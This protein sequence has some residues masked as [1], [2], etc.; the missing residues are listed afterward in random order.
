MPDFKVQVHKIRF[1]L[2]L[3][4]RSRWRSLQHSPDSLAVFKGPTFKGMEEEGE[5]RAR[6]GE[7]NG[8]ARNEEGRWVGEARESVKPIAPAR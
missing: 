7:G 6:E 3:R 4:L 8:K 2:G 1:P 5:G